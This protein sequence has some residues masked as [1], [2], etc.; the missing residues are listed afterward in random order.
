MVDI[1][2]AFLNA[3]LEEEV[4]VQ[5]AEGL[6][7]MTNLHGETY[8][9]ETQ[10]LKLRKAMYGL[11]Q[12]PRAWMRTFVKI[13]KHMGLKQCQTDPCVFY[14]RRDEEVKLIL[15]VY[16]DDVLLSG[17]QDEIDEFKTNI[18]KHLKIKEIGKVKR[19][20]GVDYQIPKDERT[21]EIHM[22]E[23]IQEI[24]TDYEEET[25]KILKIYDTP[26]TTS[27]PLLEN[28]GEKVKQDRYRSYVGRLLFGIKKCIPDCSNAIRELSQHLENPGKEQ[29]KSMERLMG[30]LKGHYKPLKMEAPTELRIIGAVDS[31]WATDKKDR[32]SI[33]GFIITIGGCIVSWMSKKQ[34]GVTLSSTEAEYVAL[35]MAATE[36]K[37][38]RMLIQEITGEKPLTSILREDNTGAI[39]LSKNEQIGP[40]AK[41]I[42]TRYRFVNDMVLEKNL[43]VKYI[44]SEDNPSDIMTKNIRE[45]DF[46]KH[47]T[48]IYGGLM[49]EPWN[50]EDV[51]HIEQFTTHIE[52]ITDD[53]AEM[54]SQG[55]MT[56]QAYMTS[57]VAA[58]MTSAEKAIKTEMK[59]TLEDGG[60][61]QQSRRSLL[62]DRCSPLQA[63]DTT[64][65]KRSPHEEGIA[66]LQDRCPMMQDR[67]P[68]MQGRCSLYQAQDTTKNKSN[69]DWIIVGRKG[70]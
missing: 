23:F 35:S 21:I 8:D 31:N 36:V 46:T 61:P 49:L 57:P 55:E 69:Q 11:V 27:D 41:H 56:S 52:Q 20:L 9:P 50:T 13:L 28:T 40:K 48:T 22:T 59:R 16:C 32:K 51:E 25:K 44:K 10:V 7:H 38:L 34:Q 30:Y 53:D 12:A 26:G 4:Y 5:I 63:Q 64:K 2:T 1:G 18:K 43:Q 42:D 29:W 45:I 66:P 47:V 39:F 3:D 58:Y 17:F 15:N 14:L 33:T 54:T 24:I 70:R 62:N 60:H 19:H 6:E 68:M 67:C 65:N 37:F